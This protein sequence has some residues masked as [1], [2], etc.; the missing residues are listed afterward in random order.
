MEV[1]KV[2]VKSD[3]LFSSFTDTLLLKL[4]SSLSGVY[5]ELLSMRFS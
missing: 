4:Y 5:N 2:E 1:Y 3:L